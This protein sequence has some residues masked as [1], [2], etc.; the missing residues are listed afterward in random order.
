MAD[1]S[2]RYRSHDPFPFLPIFATI[3]PPLFILLMTS[4]GIESDPPTD[5]K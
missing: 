3:R 2:Y 1:I 4:S 5:G